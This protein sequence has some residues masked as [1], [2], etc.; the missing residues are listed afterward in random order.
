MSAHESVRMLGYACIGHFESVSQLAPTSLFQL[1]Q[2][3][4][5][6]VPRP[7]GRHGRGRLRPHWA[8]M[9][10]P[11]P[12]PAHGRVWF[13]RDGPRSRASCR[14]PRKSMRSSCGACVALL[15]LFCGE[16][17]RVCA[18]PTDAQLAAVA[19]VKDVLR[20]TKH[21]S[22]KLPRFQDGDTD[23]S[24][25]TAD[26]LWLVNRSK[27]VNALGAL[28]AT[29]QSGRDVDLPVPEEIASLPERDNVVHVAAKA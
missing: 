10:L 28:R 12:P 2:R 16:I 5:G 6:N 11:S 13:A 25:T 14:A 23:A 26:P 21:A 7:L 22:F 24:S 19:D 27:G 29:K 3:D 1:L 4:N 20:S 17:R 9:A 18:A 8:R 15:A